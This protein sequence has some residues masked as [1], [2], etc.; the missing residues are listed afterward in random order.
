MAKK[1]KNNIIIPKS[2]DISKKYPGSGTADSILV[3]PDKTLVLPS[4]VLPFNYQIGGGLFYGK[5]MELFGAESS[6]KTLL[7]YNFAAVAQYLGGHV[8]WDDAEQAFTREWAISNGLDLSRV[9]LWNTTAIE[10]LSDW[11]ADQMIYWRSKLTHNEPILWV[12]DS[13]AALDCLEN[14]NSSQSNAKAEMGNRAKALYKMLRIRN[15]LIAELGICCICINQLRSKVG[16]MKFEDPDTTPGGQAMKFYAS[17]RIGVYGS[18]FIKDQ[19]NGVEDN[20]GRMV[21]IR[22]KKNKLAPPRPTFK[23]QCIF[24]RDYEE[25]PIGFDKYI[26]LPEIFIRTGVLT[27]EGHFYKLNGKSIAASE[28]K[29]LIKLTNDEE[30]RGTLLKK[31]RIITVSKIERKLSKIEDNLY[32]VKVSKVKKQTEDEEE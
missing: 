8:I 19:I 23:T 9:S 15:E 22:V 7:A 32:P 30:L 20:I 24:N 2:T 14:I 12:T 5:I 16:A 29:L 31:S 6:G 3:Q 26:G 10:E 11:A 1:E 28:E 25:K 17:Q 27:K 13:L 21:S 18:K 4:R